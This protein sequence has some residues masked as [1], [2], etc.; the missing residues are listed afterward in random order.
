MAPMKGSENKAKLD[1]KVVVITG[2]NTGIGKETA[3]DISKRGARV[4][5]L[6]RNIDKAN[7]AAEEISKET[8]N[9]VEVEKLDLSSL[10]SV[11]ECA[12]KILD[13]E[14][15]IDILVNNAGV[16]ACPKTLTEDGFEM[17]IGTNHFG[18]FLL[19]ELLLPLV[20]KSKESGF[21]PRI[22]IVSSLAHE[23]GQMNWDDINWEKSYDEWKAYS[24][25]KL[26]NVLHGVELA[27]RLENTGISVYSL[28]PGVIDTELGRHMQEKWYFRMIYPVM[29]VFIK[30]PLQGAQ[31][32]LYCCLEESIADHSGRY[33]SDCKEKQPSARARS[34]EDAKKLWEISEKLT[35]LK[36]D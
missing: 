19:T 16:M 11:R 36:T 21:H 12:Q 6:C 14:E 17:Q 31:T 35:G 15:K 30:T 34:E 3:K 8:G 28:H 22:V 1:G 4:I 20:K 26:A 24:Q 32:Q 10:K 13:K 33:Y 7:A 25:S 27:K 29:R 5:V 9:A 2:A 18:H 23:N